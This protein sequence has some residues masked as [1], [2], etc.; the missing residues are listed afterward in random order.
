MNSRIEDNL[1]DDCISIESDVIDLLNGFEHTL[2][3]LLDAIR[4]CDDALVDDYMERVQN[5]RNDVFS[6]HYSGD[7]RCLITLNFEPLDR[8]LTSHSDAVNQLLELREEA[9]SK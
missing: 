9:E 5:V 2:S 1:I 4:S 3:E 8:L 6:K 7:G